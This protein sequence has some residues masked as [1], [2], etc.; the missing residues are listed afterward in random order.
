MGTLHAAMIAGVIAGDAGA[1][2]KTS[3]GKDRRVAARSRSPAPR[4]RRHV[5]SDLHHR[6]EDDRDRPGRWHGR[7]EGGKTAA[8]DLIATGDTGVCRIAKK[9]QPSTRPAWVTAKAANNDRAF[10]GRWTDGC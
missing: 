2:G 10:R 6:P 4:V 9:A 3:T 8:T 1:P 5:Q 7:S